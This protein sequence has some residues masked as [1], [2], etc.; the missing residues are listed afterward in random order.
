[1]RAHKLIIVTLIFLRLISNAG[2]LKV[3]SA[4]SSEDMKTGIQLVIEQYQWSNM[5]KELTMSAKIVTCKPRTIKDGLIGIRATLIEPL[6]L[7]DVTTKKGNIPVLGMQIT[8]FRPDKTGTAKD[9]GGTYVHSFFFPIMNQLLGNNTT[10]GML[11]FE[12]GSPKLAYL[13]ELDPKKWNDLLA[14][15]LAPERTLFANV[16]AAL[17]SVV[18]CFANS[19]LEYLPSSWKRKGKTGKSIRSVIDSMY[20]SVGCLGPVPMG[21]ITVHT[22]PFAT[23]ILSNVSVLSDMHTGKGAVAETRRPQVVQSVLNGYSK[24][25]WCRPMDGTII[26]MTQYT[27]QL[28]YPTVSTTHELGVSASLYAFK[29][30]GGLESKDIIMVINQRRDYAALAYQY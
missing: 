26:P 14:M 1:M 17:G 4:V 12:K 3:G 20:Y 5:W 10:S 6:Y 15:Y 7:V 16:I 2:E 19:T 27:T 8:K 28:L 9:D 22:V 23:A 30:K 11:V 29:G 21:T 18:S 13:G 24:E 25:I